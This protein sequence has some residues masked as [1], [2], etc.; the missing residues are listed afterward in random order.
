MRFRVKRRKEPQVV[1]VSLVD[2]VLQLVIFFVLTSTFRSGEVSIEVSLPPAHAPAASVTEGITV[3]LEEDGTLRLDGKEV[4][5]KD[6]GIYFE[7]ESRKGGERT[8]L[9]R[10]DRSTS[11]GEVVA[12]LDLARAHD[13]RRLSIAAI[14]GDGESPY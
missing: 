11:H 13:M 8:V 5:R 2:V 1:L 10:A 12:V 7:A 9:L 4:S 3:E 6:L 14:T